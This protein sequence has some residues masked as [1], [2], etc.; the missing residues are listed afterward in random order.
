MSPPAS[1]VWNFWRGSSL[2][3]LNPGWEAPLARARRSGFANYIVRF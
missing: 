2:S 1:S 3:A